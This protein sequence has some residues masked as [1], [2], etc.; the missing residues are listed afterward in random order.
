MAYLSA[1]STA[2]AK[3]G[4]QLGNGGDCRCAPLLPPLQLGPGL[5]RGGAHRRTDWAPDEL[6]SNLPNALRQPAPPPTTEGW[7]AP[8]N[9][10]DAPPVIMASDPSPTS[11]TATGRTSDR[12]RGR[13]ARAWASRWTKAALVLV[14][15]GFVAIFAFWFA[16]MRDL[17]SVDTLRTYEPPLPTNV[18][19]IDGTPI[20][21]YARERRVAAEL[22]PNIRRCWSTPSSPAE[23]KTFFE[24][25]GVDYP[26]LAGAV[27]DYATKIG[28]GKRARAARR[29]P[30]RSP[31]TC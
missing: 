24:H 6:G 9:L 26:G 18:R 12:L 5:R 22:S 3:A 13:V 15:L 21:S 20:H 30:S 14:V 1:I 27:I 4:V 28:T 11:T 17:P 2:P 16:V 23:D 10:L 7:Q 19:G 29:S 25:H 8:A 31:R